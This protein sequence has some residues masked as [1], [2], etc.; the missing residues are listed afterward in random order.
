MLDPK[1]L[2]QI[3]KLTDDQL[4][5][6]IVAAGNALDRLK[7]RPPFDRTAAHDQIEKLGERATEELASSLCEFRYKLA[8]THGNVTPSDLSG[9][10]ETY[11]L[12]GADFRKLLHDAIDAPPAKGQVNP[13]DAGDYYDRLEVQK[14][15]GAAL[16]AEWDRR[17]AAAQ[18]TDAA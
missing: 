1:R 3:A 15:N 10:A 17:A 4:D 14:A 18:E 8:Q 12:T 11:L 2:D 5:I 9:L 13:Y 7:K 6:Q 16:S